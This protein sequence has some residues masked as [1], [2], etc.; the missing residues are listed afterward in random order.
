MRVK[1]WLKKVAIIKNDPHPELGLPNFP[2]YISKYD[3]SY[4]TAVGHEK[5]IK[6]LADR[7]ITEQLTHGVGFSLK[8]GKWYG[9]SHRAI[10]GFK[11]GSKC[12]VGDCHFRPKDTHDFL[13]DC[14]RFWDDTNHVWTRGV[15]ES[16][17]YTDGTK[18]D[19]VRVS[20]LYDN[21]IP[22]E[23]L[24]G[25]INSVFTAFPGIWGKGEWTAKTPAD[26]KQ[27]AIDFNRG[28]S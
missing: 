22:N 7:E 5:R 3:G 19:G 17:I 10:H 9:W 6:F 24:R 1:T 14:E 8:D 25:T 20:W 26:A 23:K 11:V 4:I 13:K 12:K 2:I 28:V 21:T 15:Y 27:M 18:A 16:F